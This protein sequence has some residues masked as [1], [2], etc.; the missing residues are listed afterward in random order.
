MKN[1]RTFRSGA[2]YGVFG[3]EFRCML[4]SCGGT[5]SKHVRTTN[6]NQPTAFSAS[7]ASRPNFRSGVGQPR[8]TYLPSNRVAPRQRKMST[9]CT[10]ARA[11]K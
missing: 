2:S 1:A 9:K 10:V 6:N 11:T 4:L 7:Q 8:N 5:H 3:A